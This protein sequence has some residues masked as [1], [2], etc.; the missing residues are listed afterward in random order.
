M[1]SRTMPDLLKAVTDELA[2]R[3]WSNYRL[4]QELKGKRPG[5]KDVPASV[6][7]EF[8][9]GESSIN[10]TDLGLIFDAIGLEPRR[11]R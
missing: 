1:L 6:V 4:V 11:K 2:R 10:S 5:K 7:Y 8:L 3:E 9:R